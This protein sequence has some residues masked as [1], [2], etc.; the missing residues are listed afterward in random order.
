MNSDRAH[1]IFPAF[2]PENI[3]PKEAETDSI[4]V[5]RVCRFGEINKSAFMSTYEECK[6]QKIYIRDLDLEY[7]GTYSTS[8]YLK[9]RDAKGIFKCISRRE[10]RAIIAKGFTGED[11]GVHQLSSKREPERKDS[12][13]DWWLY[14][15]ADPSDNFKRDEE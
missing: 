4:E 12:H 3:V 15:D 10:P 2:F 6:I 8:C 5:Y 1:K 14:A 13:T 9:R 11:Y 7:T